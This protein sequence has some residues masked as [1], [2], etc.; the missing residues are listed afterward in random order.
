[1]IVQQLNS[2]SV[3][4]CCDWVICI[5]VHVWSCTRSHSTSILKRNSPVISCGRLLQLF[6]SS[7]YFHAAIFDRV[8]VSIY[9]SHLVWFSRTRTSMVKWLKSWRTYTNT[10]QPSLLVLQEK[11]VTTW[12][13]HEPEVQNID[14]IQ[15]LLLRG[16]KVCCQLLKIGIQRCDSL[17]YDV[18]GI[19]LT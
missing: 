12:P 4:H 2:F 10:S 15:L 8:N 11:L 14:K 19:A 6:Y 17:W 13:V 3:P 5:P 7:N 18:D 9:S 1:M 16:W